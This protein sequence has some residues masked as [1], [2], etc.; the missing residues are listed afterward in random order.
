M[1]ACCLARRSFNRFILDWGIEEEDDEDEDD[2]VDGF[3]IDDDD[4]DFVRST[5]V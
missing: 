1:A 2:F 4:D 3:E 5:T